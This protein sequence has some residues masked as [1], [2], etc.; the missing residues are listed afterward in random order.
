MN[1]VTTTKP[2]NPRQLNLELGVGCQVSDDGTTRIVRA[3]VTQA[4]LQAAIDAHVAIDE[5][6]N[7]AQLE[8]AAENALANNRTFLALTSPTNAQ[9]LAQVK[10]LTR[11]NSALI[12]LVLNRLDGTD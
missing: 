5:Q 9:T 1:T 10:A 6:G 7:R 12:R 11:Q 8:Q 2:I 4:T 3:D